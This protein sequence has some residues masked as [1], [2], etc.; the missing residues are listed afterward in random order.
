M[1][2]EGTVAKVTNHSGGVLGGISDGS[3][4]VIRAAFKPTPSIAK[5]QETVSKTGEDMELV[6]TGRHDPVVV[7]RAVVVVEA[8][9]AATVMDAL[10]VSMTSRMDRIQSFFDQCK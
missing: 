3:D 9:A 2:A 10:L 6:I 7:P 5:V 1:T 4:V 8:M